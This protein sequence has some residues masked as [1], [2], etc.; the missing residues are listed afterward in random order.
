MAIVVAFFGYYLFL[1]GG[2]SLVLEGT[3]PAYAAAWLPNAVFALVAGSLALISARRP[4]A[5]RRPAVS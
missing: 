2:R 3:V 5:R 4:G 1:Y